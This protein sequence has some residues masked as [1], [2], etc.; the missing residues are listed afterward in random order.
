M[1]GCEPPAREQPAISPAEVLA[2]FGPAWLDADRCRDWLLRRLHP[3]GPACPACGCPPVSKAKLA[4]FYAGRR[5]RCARCGRFYSATSGTLLEGAKVSP[6]QVVLLAL[7]QALEIPLP[8]TA[9]LC[10]VNANT[11]RFWRNRLGASA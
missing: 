2:A 10:G 8:T 4:A 5:L 9:A 6:A 11:I 7:C 1:L 3:R